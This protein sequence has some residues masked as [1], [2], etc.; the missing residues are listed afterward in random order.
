MPEVA[1]LGPRAQRC[2]GSGAQRQLLL[3]LPSDQPQLVPELL[4]CACMEH[5]ASLLLII[6]T[7]RCSRCRIPPLDLG[8]TAWALLGLLGHEAVLDG[9]LLGALGVTAMIGTF[10]LSLFSQ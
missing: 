5:A 9:G 4:S 6:A 1:F 3:Q 2:T 10:Y 8:G 7:H